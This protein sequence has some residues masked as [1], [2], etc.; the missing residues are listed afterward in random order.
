M[1]EVHSIIQFGDGKAGRVDEDQVLGRVLFER[2]RQRTYRLDDVAAD[3]QDG[4]Q[5]AELVGGGDAVY[6]RRDDLRTAPDGQS[7]ASGQFR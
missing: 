4:C 3:S 6:V 2:L 7:I 1:G 5:C